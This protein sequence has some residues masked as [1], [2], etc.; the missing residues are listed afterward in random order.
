MEPGDFVAL[1]L[2]QLLQLRTAG[3]QFLSRVAAYVPNDATRIVVVN[4]STWVRPSLEVPAPFG[5]GTVS[6]QAGGADALRR[7]LAEPITVLLGNEDV[8]SRDLA[9]GAEA[10]AQGGTRLERGQNVFREAEVAA[11]KH[12]WTFNWR[13]ILVPGVGHSAA[14]MFASDQAL[15]A[16]Q[17]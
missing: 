6:D 11:R 3:G 7:Y 4:P 10:E 9:M 15:A 5:F 14:G 16:L 12:G 2:C 8:G 1:V 13:L 17:P